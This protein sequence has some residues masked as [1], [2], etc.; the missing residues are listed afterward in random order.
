MIVRVL[1]G[2]ELGSKPQ[3]GDHANFWFTE[4]GGDYNK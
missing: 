2:N 4:R 3:P 1:S